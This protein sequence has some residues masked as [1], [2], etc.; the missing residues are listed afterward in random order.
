MEQSAVRVTASRS[1][2][3]CSSQPWRSTPL[4]FPR[5]RLQR[6]STPD[7]PPPHGL[8]AHS[9]IISSMSSCHGC[10]LDRSRC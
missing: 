2:Q 10:C 9:V 4:P 1:K 5:R 8:T 3:R 7:I 6:T